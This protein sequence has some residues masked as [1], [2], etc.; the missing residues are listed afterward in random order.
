MATKKHTPPADRDRLFAASIVEYGCFSSLNRNGAVESLRDARERRRLIDSLNAEAAETE[1]DERT[2][3]ALNQLRRAVS[4]LD[5]F[6]L[7]QRVRMRTVARRPSLRQRRQDGRRA[8]EMAAEEAAR[9]VLLELPVRLREYCETIIQTSGRCGAERYFRDAAWLA[10]KGIS[11]G[12]ANE[13]LHGLEVFDLAAI[14]RSLA[15]SPMSEAAGLIARSAATTSSRRARLPEAGARP[16]RRSVAG[17][18]P[19]AGDRNG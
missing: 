13:V 1:H 17:G 12:I 18:S 16:R 2:A 8:R 5:A 4:E 15:H 14:E 7:I 3:F 19:S 6:Y 10:E 11:T 9:A